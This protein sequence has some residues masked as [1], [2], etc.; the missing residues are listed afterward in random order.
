MLPKH[1][2]GVGLIGSLIYDIEHLKLQLRILCVLYQA[3]LFRLNVNIF[4]QLDDKLHKF[5]KH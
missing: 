4:K 5:D 3:D 2:F 1:L